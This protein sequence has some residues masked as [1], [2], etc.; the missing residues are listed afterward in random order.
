MDLVIL[1]TVY[2]F[3]HIGSILH[4]DFDIVTKKQ[5][6]D[7]LQFPLLFLLHDHFVLS[8]AFRLLDGFDH[9]VLQGDKRIGGEHLFFNLISH[10]C[11]DLSETSYFISFRI[12]A[13]AASN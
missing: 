2:R 9:D 11:N 10:G 3:R 7:K 13:I 4:T 12:S 6:F 5:L 8:L 1:L